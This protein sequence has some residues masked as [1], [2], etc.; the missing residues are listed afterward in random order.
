MDKFCRINVNFIEQDRDL[1]TLLSENFVPWSNTRLSCKFID[2]M[3]DSGTV[4]EF[5]RLESLDAAWAS[6]R[7]K[8]ILNFCFEDQPVSLVG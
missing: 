4:D 1:M 8:M 3:I 7:F 2:K 6:V 5:R